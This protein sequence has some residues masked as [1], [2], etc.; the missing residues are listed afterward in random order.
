[1]KTVVFVSIGP[2]QL[3]GGMSGEFFEAR[4]FAGKFAERRALAVNMTLA[5]CSSAIAS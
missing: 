1:M 5:I 4:L 2:D 3:V